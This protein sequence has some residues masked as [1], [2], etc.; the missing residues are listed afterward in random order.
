MT[1]RYDPT[2]S[3][4]VM[5]IGFATKFTYVFREGLKKAVKNRKRKRLLY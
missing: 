4:I 2:V 5:E 1:K 3:E